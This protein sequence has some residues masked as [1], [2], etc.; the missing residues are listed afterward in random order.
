MR[1]PL[2]ERPDEFVRRNEH[3][4]RVIAHHLR[5]V[6]KAS[7]PFVKREDGSL[8]ATQFA[9]DREV[10]AFAAAL[11]MDYPALRKSQNLIHV[12]MKLI[13]V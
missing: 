10:E 13:M 1:W 7:Y 11:N 9:E 5:A 2:R 3:N 12:L 4:A 6:N 8:A